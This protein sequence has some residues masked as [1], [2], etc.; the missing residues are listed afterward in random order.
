MVSS[1]SH[2]HLEGPH[3]C[4]AK[5]VRREGLEADG[6]SPHTQSVAKTSTRVRECHADTAALHAATCMHTASVF[7]RQRLPLGAQQ[8]LGPHGR[9]LAAAHGRAGGI[10]ARLAALRSGL[11]VCGLRAA[12][13]CA[14]VSQARRALHSSDALKRGAASPA[15][16]RAASV[17]LL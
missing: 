14:G 9:V 12:P 10:Q 1:S 6:L 5:C 11:R 16:M 13:A 8:R 15:C 4:S 7:H 17:R 3:V 2:V